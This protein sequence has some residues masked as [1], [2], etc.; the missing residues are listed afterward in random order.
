[1]AFAHVDET[2]L[3]Y[4][5]V[6]TGP[7]IVFLNSLGSDLR[8]WDAVADRLAPRFE[9]LLYDMRGH[10]LSDAPS[11]PY[12]IADHVA[13]LAGLLDSLGWDLV[14]LAGLS[15]GGLVAQDLAA[16][17]P[18]RVAA[19]ALLDT[20]ARIGTAEMWNQRIAA[21]EAG[22][23][24]AIAPAVIGRWFAP[25]FRER[26]PAAHAGWLNMLSR[27]PATGYAGTCA[28]IRDADL[29]QAL[30]AI[31]APTLAIV[32]EADLS[33]PPDLVRGTAERIAGARFETIA[34]AGHL[35][36]IERPDETAALLARH[37]ERHAR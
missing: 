10:G 30:P 15:V 9:C 23:V 26:D 6:G 19:L 32:G 12:R 34:S 14:S 18:G 1:M 22:G 33:T 11:G 4:R 24:E 28:A 8:I 31:R 35:P 3:H 2:V 13:D 5:T 20:A 7:R 16:R 21:V 25:G 29:T 27:T 37:F 17:H 36:P